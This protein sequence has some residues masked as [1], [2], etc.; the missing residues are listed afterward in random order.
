MVARA[1]WALRGVR[2]KTFNVARKAASY[3]SCSNKK[4][5][6]KKKQTKK[7]TTTVTVE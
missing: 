5:N 1:D 2:G 6:V 7:K 4:K 3:E